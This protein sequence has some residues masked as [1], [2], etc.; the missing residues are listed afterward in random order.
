MH[1]AHAPPGQGR[2]RFSTTM[3]GDTMLFL[4][5]STP[6]PERPTTL[7]DS[8]SRYWDWMR[9]L[10]D[11]GLARSVHA[12]VGRGAV[13]LFD[14]DSNT[15]LHRLMNEWADIIPAHFDVFP[16]LDEDTAKAYLATQTPSTGDAR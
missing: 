5:I 7:I 10:L 3:V 11:S 1:A 15:T 12:R 13:A 8:R 4:V 6:R 16:L 9:P 2:V 14:V